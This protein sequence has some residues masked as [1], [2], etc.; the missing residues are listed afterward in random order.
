MFWPVVDEMI[1]KDPPYMVFSRKKCRLYPAGI[2]KAVSQILVPHLQFGSL[3]I[4]LA[5]CALYLPQVLPGT[6]QHPE[7]EY[8]Q[9]NQCRYNNYHNDVIEDRIVFQSL[10]NGSHHSR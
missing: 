10:H 5:V 1:R 7:L 4:N 8:G 3:Q 2:V 9:V 6:E